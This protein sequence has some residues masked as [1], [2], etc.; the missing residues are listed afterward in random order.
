MYEKKGDA[1]GQTF[2]GNYCGKENQSNVSLE[3]PQKVPFKLA[4]W[5]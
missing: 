3:K 2:L 4:E 5:P 1:A